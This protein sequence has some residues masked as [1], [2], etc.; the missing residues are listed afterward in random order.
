[1]CSA[2]FYPPDRVGTFFPGCFLSNLLSGNVFDMIFGSLAT[3][4]A[5][6]CTALLGKRGK[7]A[8]LASMMPVIFNGL[9]IGAVITRAYEGKSFWSLRECWG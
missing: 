3:L 8:I 4:L 2:V 6:L 5:A 1:M 7:S 9:I